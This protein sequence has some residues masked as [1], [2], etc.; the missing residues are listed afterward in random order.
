MMAPARRF[1]CLS[2][3]SRLTLEQSNATGT[4]GSIEDLDVTLYLFGEGAT[5]R[6]AGAPRPSGFAVASSASE[7]PARAI[8]RPTKTRRLKN[9]DCEVDFFFME[10]KWMGFECGTSLLAELAETRHHF[11][12]LESIF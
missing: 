9:A 12:L 4:S 3:P 7:T 11:F 8:N 5:T 2:M 6:L 10:L 1:S